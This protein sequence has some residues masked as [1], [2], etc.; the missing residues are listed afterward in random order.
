MNT[1]NSASYSR[2]TTHQYVRGHCVSFHSCTLIFLCVSVI[3]IFTPC[4]LT[5][6]SLL[7]C[8]S[9]FFLDSHSNC[10][11]S[12]GHKSGRPVSQE[13][14]TTSTSLCAQVRRSSPRLLHGQTQRVSPRTDR[15]PQQTEVRRGGRGG[16]RPSSNEWFSEVTTFKDLHNSHILVT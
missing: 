10:V 9:F 4:S 12:P 6:F 14:H 5:V 15:V 8:A 13:P 11:W 3:F 2:S 7:L 1:H 16:T